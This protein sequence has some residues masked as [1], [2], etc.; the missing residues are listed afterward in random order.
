VTFRA[1][2]YTVIHQWN[3]QAYLIDF[4]KLRNVLEDSRRNFCKTASHPRDK[5]HAS[6]LLLL[7]SFDRIK[8]RWRRLKIDIF[9]LFDCLPSFRLDTLIVDAHAADNRARTR[10]EIW[11]FAGCVYPS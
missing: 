3:E 5:V 7:G 10:K 2:L 4:R 11:N 1:L 9:P 6:R 8:D